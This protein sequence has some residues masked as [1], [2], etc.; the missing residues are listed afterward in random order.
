[1][2]QGPPPLFHQ[3]VSARAR[4]AFFSFLS[5]V[6]IVLDSRVQAL[7]TVRMGV[8]VVLYPVQ[9]ALLAPSNW[10]GRAGEFFTSV[11]SLSRENEDLR[12]AAA[13]QAQQLQRFDALSAE[14]TQLRKLL[15]MRDKLK[16][17]TVPTEVLYE[18]R[19]RFS[20]KLVL[21][22]GSNAGLTLGSPVVDDAGVIGQVTR[23][24]PL[25]AEVTLLTDQSQ[26]I[27]VQVLRNGLRGVAFGGVEPGTLELRFMPANA[28]IN[29]GDVIVTSGLDNLYP[30]GLAVGK[31]ER[32]ERGAKDQF[33][34]VVI[35]PSAGVQNDSYLLVLQVDHGT[36]P[37]LPPAMQPQRRDARKA[38]RKD[39]K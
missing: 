11:G 36:V 32:V 5:V 14:N 35:T 39:V 12:R 26:A 25:T 6:L 15:G 8:G 3:G 27:P 19:D 2:E 21:D 33:A 20:H 22:R 16:A 9:Q 29:N 10:L 18:S 4:L 23:L 37:P 24:F 17:Q 13:E 1:M 38:Q 7:E 34:R 31:V 30:A 28:D